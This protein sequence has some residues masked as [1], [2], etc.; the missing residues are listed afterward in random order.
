MQLC[1]TAEGNSA[2]LGLRLH[3]AAKLALRLALLL[4]AL[5]ATL[6]HAATITWDGGGGDL[7]WQ[8]PLNWSGDQV[9]GP[10][11]DAVINVAAN[12]TIVC[13]ADV[14]VRSVQCQGGLLIS[15]GVLTVTAGSSFI[16][17]TFTLLASQ[18][19]IAN[20][21][22][23]V[24]AARG[25][26][27]IRG[28]LMANYDAAIVLTNV[29]SLVVSDADM[30]VEA[31]TWGGGL[32]DLSGVTNVVVG[33]SLSLVIRASNGSRVDL[34][35]ARITGNIA[36]VYVSG[37]GSVVDLSGL[38][39]EWG[40]SSLYLSTLDAKNGGTL[41]IPNV[42]GLTNV[43]L[44]LTGPNG[45]PTSQLRSIRQGRLDAWDVAP[46]VSNLTNVDGCQITANS[47]A[48]LNL[49][50]VT[51]APRTA[52]ASGGSVILLTNV[53][54]LVVSYSYQ[55]L[56]AGCNGPEGLLDLSR[57]T[58]VVVPAGSQL[59]V[60][61]CNG[62]HV[63]L[64][65]LESITGGSANFLSD[66]AG[67][68]IDLSRLS[69]FLTP[70]GASSLKAQ[71]GGVI[72]I[73]NSAVF[74]LANVAV[75]LPGLI[76]QAT[77]AMVLHGQPWHSYWVEQR[78][79]RQA[80]SPWTFAARVPVTNTFQTFA[81]APPPNAAFR[82]WEFVGDPA[83]GKPLLDIGGVAP[84]AAQLVLYAMTNRTCRVETT[85]S[86]DRLPA[87]WAPWS[88]DVLMTN[89]FRLFPVPVTEAKRF[90]RA[91]EL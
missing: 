56:V 7:S 68:V 22:G 14:T 16:D 57:V 9:P 53:T 88:A 6:A 12:V 81:P 38:S 84:Q 75:T 11:D 46:D 55:G 82:V 52:A 61:T 79:T 25:T 1:E 90:F 37:A 77:P 74:L 54:S 10:S 43:N 50:Q 76:V 32:V 31:G 15:G 60:G 87:A 51:A 78:D 34:S 70:Q 24:F 2:L 5:A 91:R 63:N 39:G 86:L 66:G 4:L 18:K 69:G 21:G 28:H 83:T 44:G 23:V 48:V 35:R 27:V 45:T 89:S 85:N 80:D 73:N 67:T 17:G 72:L 71:N 42:T 62:G 41:L 47:G 58:N 64:P 19:L 40:T 59:Y 26:T 13:N 49:G 8:N 20:G 33:P 65:A 30:N 29:T 36:S 3:R